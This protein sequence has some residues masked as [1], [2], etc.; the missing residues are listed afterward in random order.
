MAMPVLKI[1][2][3]KGGSSQG[4]RSWMRDSWGR[5][6]DV[7]Y[8]PGDGGRLLYFKMLDLASCAFSWT[9]VFFFNLSCTSFKVEQVGE[10]H[11]PFVL[12]SVFQISEARGWQR[13]EGLYA[14]ETL[15]K[16]KKNFKYQTLAPITAIG[17]AESC[18]KACL[19]HFTSWQQGSCGM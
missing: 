9:L 18:F 4:K 16:K 2:W 17:R 8:S 19:L 15:Q 6:T 13:K 10:K 12:D 7:R 3:L 5:R 14:G 1:C 11:Q